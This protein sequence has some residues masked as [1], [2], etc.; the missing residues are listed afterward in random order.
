MSLLSLSR[1]QLSTLVGFAGF[2]GLATCLLAYELIN[3]QQ[4]LLRQQPYFRNGLN[5]FLDNRR[6]VELIGK[7]IK[8]GRVDLLSEG[9]IFEKDRVDIA[10][11]LKGKKISGLLHVKAHRSVDEEWFVERVEFTSDHKELQDKK[12]ILHKGN[13]EIVK[14]KEDVPVE[15]M[16]STQ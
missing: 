9:T 10:I 7:P 3:N 12:F 16:K 1:I 15:A 4:R 8:V 2:G 6:A 11:P 14:A 5:L 13:P